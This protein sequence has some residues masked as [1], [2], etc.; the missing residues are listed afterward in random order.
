MLKIG[1]SPSSTSI[2]YGEKST[3]RLLPSSK[4]KILGGS[5]IGGSFT[6]LIMNTN[7]EVSDKNPS[8]TV[9]VIFTPDV[10]K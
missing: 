5:I 10:L 8:F 3:S 2:T 4:V 7:S 1:L 9:T 6:G